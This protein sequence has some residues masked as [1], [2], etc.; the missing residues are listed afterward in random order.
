MTT[1]DLLYSDIED[2]RYEE[3]VE[4]VRRAGQASVSMLQRKMTIG[5]ACE[6]AHLSGVARQIAREGRVELPL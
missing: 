3:A 2:D 5:F 6:L 4:I 1:P